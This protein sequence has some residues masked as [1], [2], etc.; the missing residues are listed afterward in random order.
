MRRMKQVFLV[1]VVFILLVV[2]GVSGVSEVQGL[3]GSSDHPKTYSST[4]FVLTINDVYYY[5][6]DYDGYRDDILAIF[7]IK[8]ASGRYEPFDSRI[9]LYI[10]TPS[11]H[12]YYSSFCLCGYL[13]R[14]SIG[15][16]WYNTVREVGWYNFIVCFTTVENCCY[17][18]Y[19]ASKMFDPPDPGP[20]G[21]PS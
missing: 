3:I 8:S 9:Y 18:Y 6:L 19:Q 2:S 14:V 20:A 17:R 15:V 10:K 16:K 5:D 4:R 11:E 12:I 13:V 7:T 21:H 1:T